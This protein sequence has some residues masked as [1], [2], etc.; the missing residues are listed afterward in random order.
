M[1]AVRSEHVAAW[2]RPLPAIL[3]QVSHEVG[4]HKRYAERDKI[5]GPV[6][7]P[8]R[9]LVRSHERCVVICVLREV[10]EHGERH[11]EAQTVR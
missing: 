7:L 2:R 4:A 5:S 8:M 1:L 11:A 6:P 10:R 3:Q 9:R